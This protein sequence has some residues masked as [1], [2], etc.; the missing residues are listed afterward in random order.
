MQ[1]TGQTGR[2]MTEMLGVLAIAGVLSVVG[3]IGYQYAVNKI[4]ANR[5]LNDVR[6]AYVNVNSYQDL[7]LNQLTPITFTSASGYSILTQR[8]ATSNGLTDVI[9]T[10]NVEQDVCNHLTDMVQQTAWKMFLVDDSGTNFTPLNE[11][12]EEMALAFSW[13]NINEVPCDKECPENMTCIG[14]NECVCANGFEMS[15]D[16][17]C[18]EIECNYSGGIEA[19]TIQYCCEKAAGIWDITTTPSC[20]CPEGSTFN[21]TLCLMKD[22]CSYT[23]ITPEISQSYESDCAYNFISPEISQSYESDC[24]YNFISPEISQ[25][26]ESDCTYEFTASDSNGMISITMKEKTP[27]IS[28]E[29]CILNWTDSTCSSAVSSYGTGITKTI[30]G[31]CASLNEYPSIC[32]SKEGGNVSME[33]ISGKTCASDEYC[34]LNWG[35]ST[36]SSAVSSYGAG[37]TKTIYGRCAS[38]NEYPSICKSKEGGNVSMEPISG[39][40]CASDEY[41]IL[42]W[43]DSTCSSAVSSYG[44]GITKTIYGRC[45]SLNEYP[46]ICKSTEGGNV[47]M[48]AKKNCRIPDT[49]CSILWGN[50]SCQNVSTYGPNIQRDL[51][52]I[53]LPYNSIG[54]TTCPFK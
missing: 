41:C 6:L 40:T 25:S 22:W 51:Y 21:G 2:S 16:S 17:T 49:Y 7:P 13:A 15:E 35:D 47:S 50:Q 32:K 39:K 33:P 46:S 34:I 42:N 20:T 38:L 27:C 37:I 53:C 36:C 18:Q 52:G 9:I 5:I 28:G 43:G 11:C 1:L 30:Y 48:I 4:K 29:Y 31:R 8:V 24:A 26:Y 10:K 54:D 14:N 19:Q 45:A 44:A 3:V 12:V 23:F